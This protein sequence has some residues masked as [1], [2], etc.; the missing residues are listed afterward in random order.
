MLIQTADPT[1][2]PVTLAQAKGHLR[3]DSDN[4]ADDT[5]IAMLI[6]AAR[7]YA[8]SYTGRSFITQGWRLVIDA[9]PGPGFMGV[10]WGSPYS[11]PPQAIQLERG[12]VQAVSSITYMDMNGAWQTM[13]PA[14]YVAELSGCPARITPVFGQIWPPTRPQIGS[15]KVDY[16]A[17]YGAGGTNVPEGIRQWILM[18]VGTLYEQREEI[19]ILQ[20]GKVEQLPYVDQLLDPYNVVMA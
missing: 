3:V 2:E 7:R 4:T 17:G 1:S 5:L 20:K 6:G 15:V 18:R 11:L 16:T 9:F 19:A 12:I 8:E 14:N 13:D 10:P